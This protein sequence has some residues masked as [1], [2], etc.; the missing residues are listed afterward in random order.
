MKISVLGYSGAGKSTLSRELGELYGAPVLHMDTVQ[1]TSDWKERERSEKEKI[2]ADFL[3]RNS[4]WVIDGNYSGLYFK[5]RLEESDLIV[6]LLFNRF[7]CFGGVVSRYRTFKGRT[8]PDMADGCAEK[9]DLEF[10][11]WVLFEGRTAKRRKKYKRAAQE[12]PEKIVI[13]K[14]RRQLNA[15]LEKIKSEHSLLKKY[16]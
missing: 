6:M 8:R 13:L 3:D 7:V 14:N 15:F 2:V 11:R 4:S 9:L 5:R 16:K 1:Y 10:A 12:F